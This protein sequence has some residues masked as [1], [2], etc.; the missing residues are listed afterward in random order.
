MKRG[1]IMLKSKEDETIKKAWCKVDCESMT[2][3]IY[4]NFYYYYRELYNDSYKYGVH[5]YKSGQSGEY[6]LMNKSSFFE[7]FCDVQ[8]LRKL[9]LEK[10][11]NRL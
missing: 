9:K 7:Y 8:E 6:I 1:K 11:K 3:V 2:T 5:V 10:L 4:K